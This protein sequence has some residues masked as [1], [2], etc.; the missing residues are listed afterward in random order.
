MWTPKSLITTIED[1][2]QNKNYQASKWNKT[3]QRNEI[4]LKSNFDL[5]HEWFFLLHA[6]TLPTVSMA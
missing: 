6:S 4:I 3:V 2:K 5:G 1:K